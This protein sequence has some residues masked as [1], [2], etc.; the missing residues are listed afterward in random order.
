MTL[1][2]SFAVTSNMSLYARH[3]SSFLSFSLSRIEDIVEG[4][5]DGTMAEVEWDYD[6][7]RVGVAVDPV[8]HDAFVARWLRRRKWRWWRRW[9]GG[10]APA[11][12]DGGGNDGNSPDMY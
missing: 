10:G 9:G 3:S 7:N 2:F 6:V 1:A 11:F 12:D 5:D 4:N 8:S